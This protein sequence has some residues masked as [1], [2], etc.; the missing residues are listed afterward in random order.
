MTE[1]AG[2]DLRASHTAERAR[3]ARS[4]SQRS[5]VAS[6]DIPRTSGICSSGSGTVSNGEMH[7]M[8]RHG[9]MPAA[10]NSCSPAPCAFRS[11]PMDYWPAG[12]ARRARWLQDRGSLRVALTL[13]G[14]T[15]QDSARALASLA[16]ELQ[17]RIGPFATGVRRHGPGARES[18]RPRRGLGWIGKHPNLIA[19]EPGLV[20]LSR[21]ILTDLPRH[22]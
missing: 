5:G 22:R 16:A 8:Q 1:P 17:Q 6:I 14:A 12:G 19:R 3:P 20:V 10:R 13:W 2:V 9:V 21:E 15:T 18:P 4:A 11:A 7:Y